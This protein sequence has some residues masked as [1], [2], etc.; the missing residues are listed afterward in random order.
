MR[1]TIAIPI[2]VALFCMPGCLL[3]VVGVMD[4]NSLE[5]GTR[6]DGIGLVR[7][8]ARALLDRHDERID[9]CDGN[10]AVG[11]VVFS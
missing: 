2:L 8:G 9:G 7:R 1:I 11:G 3:R 6:G 10:M 5:Y 4:P